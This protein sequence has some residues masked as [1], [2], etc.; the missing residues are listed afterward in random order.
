MLANLLARSINNYI[1]RGAKLSSSI[2][3]LQFTGC[4][5]SE[6]CG[7]IGYVYIYA[8]KLE[9]FSICC[10]HNIYVM[11]IEKYLTFSYVT[12]LVALMVIKYRLMLVSSGTT[13][14]FPI[15]PML[16]FGK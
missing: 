9:S 2:K 8:K 6:I 10:I 12:L 5:E 16:F 13:V 15:A 14:K 1:A 11:K 4:C 3:K 7:N